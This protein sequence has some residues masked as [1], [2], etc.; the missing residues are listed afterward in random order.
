MEKQDPVWD[1]FCEVID[2]S[3]RDDVMLRMAESVGGWAD[4]ADVKIINR[5][6][7]DA[8][9]CHAEGVLTYR[10]TE[11][12]FHMQDGNWNGTVLLGW[13]NAG[14][15]YQEHVPIQWAL[16]PTSEAIARQPADRLLMLWDHFLT[17]PE[18][19]DVPRKYAYDRRFQPGGQIENHYKSKVAKWGLRL[20]SQ[21]EADE[22]RNQLK[23]AAN[24]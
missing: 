6:R 15:Q 13:E 23:E 17:R 22:I 1:A 18:V 7:Y 4:Y 9:N 12:W 24:V 2:E 8:I 16:A 3:D 5:D 10:D 19:R 11:Y 14:E 20:V 21:E